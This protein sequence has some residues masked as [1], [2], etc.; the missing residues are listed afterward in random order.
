LIKS[1]IAA[2]YNGTYNDLPVLTGG[3]GSLVLCNTVVPDKTVMK[4]HSSDAILLTL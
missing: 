1:F 4:P 2:Q 3:S